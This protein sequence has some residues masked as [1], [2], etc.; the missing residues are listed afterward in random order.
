MQRLKNNAILAGIAKRSAIF[1]AAS[2]SVAARRKTSL[3]SCY[4]DT[5]FSSMVEGVA[6]LLQYGTT[7]LVIKLNLVVLGQ[8][9]WV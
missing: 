3:Q 5:E 6:E 1:H 4:S 8:T 2:V 9:A 7:T